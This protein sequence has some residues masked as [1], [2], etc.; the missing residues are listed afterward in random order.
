[1]IAIY[2]GFYFSAPPFFV[3]GFYSEDHKL[4][5][6][7]PVITPTFQARRRGKGQGTERCFFQ[8]S[9]FS[10]QEISPESNLVTSTY[11]SVA[12]L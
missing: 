3:C 6:K 1:M 2:L 9:H 5:A 10:L 11:I 4:A 12:T 8:P 7:V